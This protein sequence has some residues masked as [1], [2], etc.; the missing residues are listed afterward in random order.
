MNNLEFSQNEVTEF[1]ERII[2]MRTSHEELNFY[3][4]V[5]FFNILDENISIKCI[6]FIRANFE[7]LYNSNKGNYTIF[8]LQTKY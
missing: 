5:S 2:K 3:A 1:K 4:T 8:W 7:Y 6:F